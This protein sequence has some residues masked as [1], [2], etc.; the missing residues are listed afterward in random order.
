MKKKRKL[1]WEIQG[2]KEEEGGKEI[3]YQ[4]GKKG[5][6]KILETS[7]VLVKHFFFFP[8]WLTLL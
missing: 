3:R 2:E 8:V 5:N 7:S 1:V 4:E 6:K